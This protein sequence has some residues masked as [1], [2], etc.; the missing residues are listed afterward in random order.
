MALMLICEH[1]QQRKKEEKEKKKKTG[2]QQREKQGYKPFL[3]LCSRAQATLSYRRRRPLRARA[4]MSRWSSRE[5]E[6]HSGSLSKAIGVEEGFYC[7]FFFVCGSSKDFCFLMEI[8]MKEKGKVEQKSTL[9]FST[10]VHT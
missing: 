3:G 6:T 1:E 9:L 2:T 8:D 4:P 5:R 7:L 10:F